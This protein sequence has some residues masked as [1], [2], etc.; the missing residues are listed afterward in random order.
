[1]S[2]IKPCYGIKYDCRAKQCIHCKYPIS[3][4]YLSRLY[5]KLGKKP[6]LE[7]SITNA[8]IQILNSKSNMSMKEIKVLLQGR[9]ESTKNIH[10]YI[11]KLKTAG[12][13]DINVSGRNRLYNL[14]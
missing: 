8:I 13:I 12:I 14:R 3:C 9:F 6:S 7:N 10:Y 11:G 2:T 1:M 4:F 5:K